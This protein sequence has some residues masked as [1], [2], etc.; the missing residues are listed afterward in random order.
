MKKIFVIILFFIFTFL[1]CSKDQKPVLRYQN[2]DSIKKLITGKTDYPSSNIIVFTDPHYYP[3]SL[4]L[5][6]KLFYESLADDKKFLVDGQQ[7]IK[8]AITEMAQLPGD[9]II[10]SGDMTK[11][12]E[13]KSHLEFT[14]LLKI[15]EDSGKPVFVVPGNHDVNNGLAMDF[16]GES[17]KKTDTVTPEDFRK[18]YNEYGYK[19]SIYRD[20]DSLS[21]VVEPVKGLWLFCLD[22]NKW[23]ENKQDKHVVSGGTFYPETLSWIEEM[24]IESKKQKKAVMVS[25]HHAVMEHFKGQRKFYKDFVIDNHEEISRLFAAYGVSLVFTGHYHAQ[26][27]TEKSFPEFNKTLYDIETGS[28]VTYPLPYRQLN[29]TS[30]Q[31]V[32]IKSS[33]MKKPQFENM[34]TTEYSKKR[35]YDITL[36]MVSD[37]MGKYFVSENGQKKLGP[38]ITDAYILHLTGDEPLQKDIVDDESIGFFGSMALKLKKDLIFGWRTDLKPA[39]NNVILDL[40]K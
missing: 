16:S 1:F 39:D 5:N 38:Q 30:D 29:I 22:S 3:E 11:D 17:P 33:Y 8:A 32:V 40:S 34:D 20:E 14:K 25:M 27:I 19:E 35:Y 18:I 2:D 37:A 13:Y 26:D 28:F 15:L 7:I 24:L 12:G 4:G 36:K 31:N 10:L 23:R 9:F 21:Y 6:T